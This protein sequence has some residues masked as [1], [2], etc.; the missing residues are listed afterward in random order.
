MIGSDPAGLGRI[1]P[2]TGITTHDAG[3]GIEFTGYDKPNSKAIEE[4]Q[5]FSGEKVVEPIED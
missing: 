1:S 3:G 2:S 5:S 4:R